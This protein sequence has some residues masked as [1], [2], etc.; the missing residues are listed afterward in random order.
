VGDVEKFQ[1]T[2]PETDVFRAPGVSA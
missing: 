2:P 1:G